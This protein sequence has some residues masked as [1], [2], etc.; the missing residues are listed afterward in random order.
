MPKCQFG[1][2]QPYFSA[3]EKEIAPESPVWDYQSI[4]KGYKAPETVAGK[5]AIPTWKSEL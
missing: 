1:I 2:T 4:A 3:V 5:I